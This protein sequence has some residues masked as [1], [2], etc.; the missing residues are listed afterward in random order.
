M[1]KY[2]FLS[3]AAAA[4]AG[5]GF[6]ANAS[7]AV[8]FT[9]VN[10]GAPTVPASLSPTTM[11]GWTGYTLHV[12]SDSGNITAVDF[13]TVNGAAIT[14]IMAQRTPD[15]DGTGTYN[16]ADDSSATGTANNS[17]TNINNSDS[18]FLPLAANIAVGTALAE[19]FTGPGNNPYAS[20]SSTP[21][22]PT[23]A[24]YGVGNQLSGAF[25]VVATAQSN[26]MD[27]AYIVVQN[28]TQVSFANA[29]VATTGG[30][31]T[32]LT[33][34]SPNSAPAPEPAS[35]GVLALGGLALIARRRKA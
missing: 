28:G 11:N 10:D 22:N 25:G 23:A 13:T 34:T 20:F 30:T 16:A 5:L 14:G 8:T 24:F 3:L 19:T 12:T 6:A 32:G 33:S 9:W 26:S 35:L 4:V 21:G 15:N 27:L 7:A 1:K 31:F 18:H 29:S 2:G 17:A